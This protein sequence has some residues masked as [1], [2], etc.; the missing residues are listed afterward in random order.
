MSRLKWERIGP[1]PGPPLK[2]NEAGEVLGAWMC[3]MMEGFIRRA[4]DEGHAFDAPVVASDPFWHECG[5]TRVLLNG[6]TPLARAWVEADGYV[7]RAKAEWLG[8]V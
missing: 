8:D 4:M 1:P 3:G 2:L 5:I 7:L 6:S